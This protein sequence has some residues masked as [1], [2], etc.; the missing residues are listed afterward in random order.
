MTPF[1]NCSSDATPMHRLYP[2]AYALLVIDYINS[3]ISVKFGRSDISAIQR[4][5]TQ[6]RVCSRE[7]LV[8]EWV[9]SVRVPNGTRAGAYCIFRRSNTV[10]TPVYRAMRVQGIKQTGLSQEGR[11][12]SKCI[13]SSAST[14]NLLTK[15]FRRKEA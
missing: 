15:C 5:Q 3:R 9:G 2:E 13:F 11:T 12:L 8:F 10:L 7:G 14:F 4:F 1:L 6:K